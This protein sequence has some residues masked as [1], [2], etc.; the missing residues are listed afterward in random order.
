M[1]LIGVTERN[2]L[3]LAPSLSTKKLPQLS[4]PRAG[5]IRKQLEITRKGG[6]R[7]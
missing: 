6:R 5:R 2:C 7:G 1:W 3:A 4:L